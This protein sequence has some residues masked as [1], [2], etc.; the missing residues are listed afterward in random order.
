MR[1]ARWLLALAAAW[2]GGAAGHAGLAASIPADGAALAAPPSSIELRFTEPVTPLSVRLVTGSASPITLTA[3]QGASDVMTLPL[4]AALRQG[5]Y[6]VSFRVISMDSHPVGGSIVF[7]IGE[8]P[9]PRAAGGS[10]GAELSA[11]T[12]AL[13]AV[14][15]LALL[16]A[17]GGALFVLGIARFP[18]ERQVLRIAGVVAIV[19]ALAGIG[20]QGADMTGGSFW[21]LEGWRSGLATSLGRSSCVAAGGALAIV[22][23]TMLSGGPARA[24]LLAAGALAAIASLPLTGH[25]VTAH[26]AAVAVTA[27]AAHGLAAAF[28]IGS[29]AA[30]LAIVTARPSGDAAA[31]TV[32]RR[33]SRWGALAVLTLV[34]AGS[35]FVLL[36][37]DS[38]AA[39]FGS[40]YGWLIVC[41]VVLLLALVLLAVLNR[42]RWLPMLERGEAAAGGRL[43]RSIGAEVALVVCVVGVTAV[44]VHTPP[45]RANGMEAA[46]EAGYTQKLAYKGD[47]AEV[48]VRP[49]RAGANSIVVRFRDRE[50]LPFD[51]EEVLVQVANHAA[52]VEPAA[53]P[54]RRIG[55]G[56]YRRDGSELAFP[57][58]W[59]IEVQARIDSGTAIF[60]SQVPVR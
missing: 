15:D 25:A 53:R 1:R 49:A 14:R 4:P 43:R 26:P 41:K 16:I 57:G 9:P 32:L 36:Q 19:A 51:P 21:T 31:A 46:A 27:L 59:T 54:I 7:A 33:F 55:P 52:G 13:R 35:S 45:P 11:W 24:A 48:S 30:L 50:G 5:L 38:V 40:R 12:A 44:L 28:W 23:A 17:A 34:V 37:L 10:N 20:L 22:V 2:A 3:P 60:R 42:F 47:F 8:R 39:L 58:L 29:L 56:E 18:S 6:V